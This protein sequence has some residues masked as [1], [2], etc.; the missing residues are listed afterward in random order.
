[1]LPLI[2]LVDNTFINVDNYLPLGH[3]LDVVGCCQLALQ[4]CCLFIVSSRY[5]LDLLVGEAQFVA[6]IP[7]EHRLAQSELDFLQDGTP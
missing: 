4:L 3:I 2:C 6:Q 1:M 5:G 7:G